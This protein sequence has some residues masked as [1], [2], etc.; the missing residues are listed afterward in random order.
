MVAIFIIYKFYE[1]IV[2]LEDNGKHYYSKVNN[3]CNVS[4]LNKSL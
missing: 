1:I 4:L 3:E 2:I